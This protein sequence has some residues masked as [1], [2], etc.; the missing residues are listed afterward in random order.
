MGGVGQSNLGQFS[1]TDRTMSAGQ[2][3]PF[4]LNVVVSPF[5]TI[6]Y[7]TTL[8]TGIVS[9]SADYTTITVVDRNSSI[10]ILQRTPMSMVQWDNPVRDILNMMFHERY[11]LAI[12]NGGR[13][14]VTAKNVRIDLNHN[15]LYTVRTITPA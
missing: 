3:V 1:G 11:G 5:Q 10:L 14:A 8:S 4:G 12:L 6:N 15:P 13:S 2:F 7:N 9:G